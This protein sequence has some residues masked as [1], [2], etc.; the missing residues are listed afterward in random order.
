MITHIYIYVIEIYT[1]GMYKFEGIVFLGEGV[2]VHEVY[3]SLF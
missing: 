2:Q 1:S 3:S